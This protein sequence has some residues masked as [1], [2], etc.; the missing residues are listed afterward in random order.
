M[1][2]LSKYLDLSSD[3][4]SDANLDLLLL[5]HQRT[6]KN[7]RRNSDYLKK[8]SSHGEFVLTKELC[9]ERFTNYFRLNKAEFQEVH[10]LVQPLISSEGC[11]AQK[12]IGSEEK[13]AVFL[14]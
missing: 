10:S 7:K 6:R 3:S 1:S 13:L 8:R 11:N 4:D 2:L 14:R 12:P 5:L 9:S